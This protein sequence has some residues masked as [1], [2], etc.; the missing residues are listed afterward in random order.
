[1]IPAEWWGTRAIDS[2]HLGNDLAQYVSELRAAALREG[3]TADAVIIDSAPGQETLRA[4]R[5]ALTKLMDEVAYDWDQD[6]S[7][8]YALTN[9][10]KFRDREY[11]AA[12]SGARP[13]ETPDAH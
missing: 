4:V 8:D 3:G 12:Q 2:A 10:R 9:I 7:D 6:F 13:T 5:S 1:V 11:P